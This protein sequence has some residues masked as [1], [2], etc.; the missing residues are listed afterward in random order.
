MTLVVSQCTFIDN[1]AVGGADEASGP[2]AG[3]GWGGGLANYN[4][5]LAT[6]TDSTFT[7]NQALG[8]IGG[9]GG[10]GGDGL[11]GGLAN[12]LGATLTLAGCT[13]ST[14]Q[15]AGGTGGW[16]QRRRRLRRRSL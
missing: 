9:A 10:K 7:G 12:L 5:A 16:R 3:D 6:V 14:N 15:A 2:F 8:N 13:L 4:G 1:R 11:G